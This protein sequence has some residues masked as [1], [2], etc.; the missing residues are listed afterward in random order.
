[1]RVRFRGAKVLAN[2]SM[3]ANLCQG[4]QVPTPK[5]ERERRT[6]GTTGRTCQRSTAPLLAAPRPATHLPHEAGRRLGIAVWICHSD[7]CCRRV[8]LHRRRSPQA[9]PLAARP[10]ARCRQ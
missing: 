10:S 2:D 9:A 5:Q 8:G 3:T 6:C 1:M 4:S 7:S